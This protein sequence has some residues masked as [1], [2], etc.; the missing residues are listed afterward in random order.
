MVH[1]VTIISIIFV[2]YNVDHFAQTDGIV[3]LLSIW[4][5]QAIQLWKNVQ[6]ELSVLYHLKQELLLLLDFYVP[7]SIQLYE[8]EKTILL[9][10][11][12]AFSP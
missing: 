11:F 3:L 5:I 1:N 2:P 6:K 7:L 4:A 9:R 8:I 10:L 12:F